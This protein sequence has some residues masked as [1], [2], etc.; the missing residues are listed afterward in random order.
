MWWLLDG[1][2][3]GRMTF[4]E[5]QFMNDTQSFLGTTDYDSDSA[6]L[7]DEVVNALLRFTCVIALFWHL[8]LEGHEPTVHT[9][10]DV[11][12]PDHH[13]GATMDLEAEHPLLPELRGD[14]SGDLGLT[15]GCH[16]PSLKC[17]ALRL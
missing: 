6:R 11:G 16:Q 1:G 10:D 17:G 15:L 9:G 2:T 7:P 4:A 13:H 14:G 5:A 8:G 3:D 12:Q